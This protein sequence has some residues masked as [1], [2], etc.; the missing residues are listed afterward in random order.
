[1]QRIL[2][3]KDPEATLAFY[4]EFDENLAL[5]RWQAHLAEKKS[6]QPTGWKKKG[7]R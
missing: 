2:G 6:R 5:D 1:M 7:L 4:A 3:H